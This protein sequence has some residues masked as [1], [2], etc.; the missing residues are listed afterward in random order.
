[1]KDNELEYICDLEA[2]ATRY[3]SILESIF[4]PRDSRFVLGTI[5]HSEEGPCTYFPQQHHF[6]GGCRVDIFI[7]DQPWELHSPDQGPWQIAHE[8]VHLLDPGILGT[9]NILEEGLATWFQNEPKY[10]TE[11]VQRY[12]SKHARNTPRYLEAQKLVRSSLPDILHAVKELRG[13]RVRIRDIK[14][15]MLG[16]LL[17]GVELGTIERL[18]ARFRY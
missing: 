4:G 2:H 12:I 3:L 11:Q 13:S 17:P 15:D 14:A 18:C 9:C 16:A 7:S 10:H 5:Q 1:M 8:C 6:K